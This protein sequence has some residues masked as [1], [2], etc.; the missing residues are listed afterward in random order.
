MRRRRNRPA[1]MAD[2]G[3]RAVRGDR[4]SPT[5]DRP[6]P[7]HLG[8][9]H[10]HRVIPARIYATRRSR[11]RFRR[12]ATV[13]DSSTPVGERSA[14]PPGVSLE[15]TPHVGATGTAAF[16]SHWIEN[17]YTGAG[18]KI[19]VID[20]FDA[21]AV[22]AA[23]LSG[24]LPSLPASKRRCFVGP[25]QCTFGTPGVFHGN[26]EANAVFDEAPGAEIY[27]V[28]VLDIGGMYT[29]IDWLA[30][31]GVTIVSHTLLTAFDGPGNGTGPAAAVVDCPSKGIGV[32]PVRG[33]LREGPH[34]TWYPGQHWRWSDP[35]N[36]RWLNFTGTDETL[37]TFCGAL[38][39]L[40][41]SDW[42]A[43]RTDYELW[44]ADFDFATGR[45]VHRGAGSPTST[46][47]PGRRRSRATTCGGC[48][49]RTRRWAR[50][51]TPTRTATSRS[52]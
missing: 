33:R 16:T 48:A 46:R 21:A 40:R 24:D 47:R 27:L 39:G 35:D 43:A 22:D 14:P 13:A 8:S 9:S 30:S 5:R 37:G 18:V 32:V 50:S 26:Y 20:W 11:T 44:A 29:A 52:R 25:N 23:V 19:G 12:R 10:E 15:A 3:A 6:P 34:H 38:M 41:W 7:P 28:E 49:T 36:D 2:R 4:T 45:R 42:G 1:V 31:N 51:T 17:G